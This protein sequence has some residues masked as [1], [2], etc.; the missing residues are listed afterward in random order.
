MLQGTGMYVEA[1]GAGCNAAG[2]DAGGA[3]AIIIAIGSA[4]GAASAWS[5]RAVVGGTASAQSRDLISRC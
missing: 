5:P 4:C 3:I 2:G 1:H